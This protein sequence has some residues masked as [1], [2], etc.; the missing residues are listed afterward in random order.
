MV[1]EDLGRSGPGRVV[2]PG[3]QRLV[4]AVCLEEVGGVFAR[5]AS[6][7]ARNNRDWYRLVDLCAL[8]STLIIDAE[9]GYDP[10]NSNDRLLPGLKVTMSE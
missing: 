5:E 1:D 4:S 8:T 9:G 2:R 6:R 7:L 3:F 10:H